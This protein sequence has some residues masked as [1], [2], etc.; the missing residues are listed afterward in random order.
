[1][2]AGLYG[3]AFMIPMRLWVGEPGLWTHDPTSWPF[4][5]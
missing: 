1:V 2:V 3:L 4:G 5:G